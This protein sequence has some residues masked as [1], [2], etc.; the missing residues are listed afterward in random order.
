MAAISFLYAG[1]SDGLV[2]ASW[3][4]LFTEGKSFSAD[5]MFPDKEMQNLGKFDSVLVSAREML[6]LVDSSLPH[7]DHK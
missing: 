7:P 5:P 2:A 4:S 6:L 1:S 3:R